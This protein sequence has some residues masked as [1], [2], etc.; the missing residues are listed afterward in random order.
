MSEGY[1]LEDDAPQRAYDARLMR[2]LLR[3]I[4]PYRR[5]ML[6]A[7]AL[8]CVVAVISNITPLLIMWSVDRYIAGAPKGDVGGVLEG[9][10]VSDAGASASM[11]RLFQLTLILAALVVIEAVLRYIQLVIVSYVGQ[12]TMLDMRVGLFEHLQEMSLS[13]LDRHPVGRLMSR[14]TNDVERIQQT[15]VS[16]V[17]DVASDLL[18]LLAILCFMFAINWQLALI[19]LSPVPL[20][21]ATSAVFRKYAQRSFLEIR[22]KVARFSAYMQETISGMRVVQLFRR[23]PACFEAF[24][25]KNA[26][27][28]DEWFRQVRNFALYF[29]A[30]DFLSALSVSLIILY[31]G[32]QFLRTGAAVS[33]VAS[34]GTLFSY[35]FWAERFFGPIRALADRYNMLLEAMA[36]SERVFQLIDTPPDIQDRPGAARLSIPTPVEEQMLET[37]GRDGG[38]VRRPATTMGR[39]AATSPLLGQVDFDHVSFA[40][41]SDRLVLDDIDLHIAP[42]ERVAVVGHTGAGKSTLISLLVRFYDVTQGAIRVDGVDVRDYEQASLRRNIGLVLQDVFLFSGT[43]AD[44][45]R[46]GDRDMDDAIVRRCAAHVNAARFIERLPGGYNYSV[47]ERGCNLSTGQRQLL[48]FART[49]AHAP[50]VLVLDEATSNVDPETEALIQDAINKLLAGRTSIVVAHR[51]ST[52]QHCDR[53]VVMHHGR[54]REMGTHQELLAIGGLYRTL[55]ELQYK[56]QGRATPEG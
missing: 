5:W 18:T 34:V 44:N 41:D 32:V 51:L 23:E 49:L 40:Y 56:D 33:G 8:L 43:I 19:A 55:Y 42:G 21:L 31:C 3:Y 20:I 13:F 2:R 4:R 28:R 24:D 6:F 46:L 48:A 15:I 7:V 10:D 22:R 12:R 27:H 9:V 1:H 52:I 39:P 37:C 29:P 38:S 26:D 14:V 30:V 11:D 25:E 17:V 16:G 54:I 35:V 47:G 45:I 36:S 53:I 50:R